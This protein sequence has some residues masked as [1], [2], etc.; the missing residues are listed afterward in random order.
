[1]KRLSSLNVRK[2]DPTK[3]HISSSI[4]VMNQIEKTLRLSL[5]RRKTKYL[6]FHSIFQFSIE[7]WLIFRKSSKPLKEWMWI[8]PL[9]RLA[10]SKPRITIPTIT[11]SAS[12]ET[13]PF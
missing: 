2:N 5:R 8:F 10:I 11:R 6:Q 7:H 4:I 1:M 9:L 13:P 12:N 3:N